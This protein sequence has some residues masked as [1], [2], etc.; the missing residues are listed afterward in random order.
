MS[1]PTSDHDPT[2]DHDPTAPRP[3]TFVVGA[4]PGIGR[5]VASRFAARGHALGLMART[6]RTLDATRAGLAPTS[7]P[8]HTFE[9]DAGDEASLRAALDRAVDALGVPEV[10]VYNA[11]VIR[12][13]RPGELSMHEH[14]RSWSVNVL[15]AITAI[16]HL[17]A[18]MEV[19]GGTAII[20]GGMPQ[21]DPRYLSLSLGKAGV[22]AA[23]QMLA[24]EHAPRNLHIATVT[25][26]GPV[27]PGTAWDPDDIAEHYTRLHDQQPAEW[28]TF[29]CHGC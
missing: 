1:R 2:G 12:A 28:E 27:A 24:A 6:T 23:T 9:V 10:L 14:Q 22:R 3:T 13:D 25:V 17:A 4:G 5:A 19:E 7:A 18:R 16:E 15:G 20:T 29:A 26:G 11:A 21:P 8:V